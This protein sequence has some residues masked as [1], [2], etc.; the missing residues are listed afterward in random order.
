MH[1]IYQP[2]PPYSRLA[3]DACSSNTKSTG[4]IGDFDVS[5][6]LF[7]RCSSCSCRR[8][9]GMVEESKED[10]LAAYKLDPKNKAVRKELQLLKVRATRRSDYHSLIMAL[11]LLCIRLSLQ[12]LLSSLPL[13]LHSSLT[14]SFYFSFI[15]PFLSSLF[16][17][18][19]VACVR[20]R[21][22]ILFRVFVALLKSKCKCKM[23]P[24]IFQLFKTC[25]V[26]SSYS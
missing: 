7:V 22:V 14:P 3:P 23:L 6:V 2:F 4:T 20:G 26:C 19:L 16:P 13:L 25:Q 1:L 18:S 9:T 11:S 10:L 17:P 15:S 21:E 5:S 24:G 8:H 12:P